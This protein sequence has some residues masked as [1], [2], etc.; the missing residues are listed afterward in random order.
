MKSHYRRLVLFVRDIAA[1]MAVTLYRRYRTSP[2]CI[3]IRR[4]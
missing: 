2:N 1:K 4:L 3:P